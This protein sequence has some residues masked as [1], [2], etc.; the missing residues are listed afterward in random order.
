MEQ[1]ENENEFLNYHHLRYFWTV[2]KEGSLRRASEKLKVSQPAMSTQ[3]Q[4][5]GAALG[6][7]LFSPSGQIHGR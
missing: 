6:G 1:S 5:L 4:Q 7:E 2:A 3:I